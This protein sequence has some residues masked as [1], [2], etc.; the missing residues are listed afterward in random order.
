MKGI[1]KRVAGLAFGCAVAGSPV[2]AADDGLVIGLSNSYFGNTWR[3]IMVDAY[4][5]AANEAKEAGRIAD[6]VTLNGDGSVNAQVA[7]IN[8]LILR[9]VDAILVVAASETALNGVI[10]RACAADILVVG[11]DNV[12]TA[13]CAYKLTVDFQDYGTTA[14]RGVANVLNGEGNILVVRGVKGAGAENAIYT[15]QQT[16]LA[17]NAGLNVVAEVFGEWSGARC[18]RGR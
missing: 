7:H 12:P 15:G 9:G 18:A 13:P 4:E 16:V 10:G 17:E 11:F 2:L 3:H 1:G 5:A 8:D 6:F 14:A